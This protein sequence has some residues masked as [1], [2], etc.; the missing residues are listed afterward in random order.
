MSEVAAGLVGRHKTGPG[1]HQ[2]DALNRGIH[3]AAAFGIDLG[4]GAVEQGRAHRNG[5][6][7]QFNHTLTAFFSLAFSRRSSSFSRT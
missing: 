7:Q 5:S 6:G 4:E 2:K 3:H 1:A